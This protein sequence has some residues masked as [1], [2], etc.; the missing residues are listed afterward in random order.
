MS[1]HHDTEALDAAR[2][3]HVLHLAATGRLATEGTDDTHALS[4]AAWNGDIDLTALQLTDAGRLMLAKLGP[5]Y[6]VTVPPT[7][8]EA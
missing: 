7:A 5:A 4:H 1:T 2:L 6:G 3:V 8:E